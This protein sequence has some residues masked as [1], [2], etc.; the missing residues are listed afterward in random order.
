MVAAPT[1][2]APAITLRRDSLLRCID[3]SSDF[4]LSKRAGTAVNKSSAAP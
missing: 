4:L 1:P 2:A 3:I